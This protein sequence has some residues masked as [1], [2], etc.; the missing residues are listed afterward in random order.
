MRYGL[1]AKFRNPW[2]RRLEE[3]LDRFRALED[4]SSIIKVEPKG[5]PPTKYI[6]TFKGRTLAPGPRGGIVE[7][8]EQKAEIQLGLEYPRQPPTMR[9]LTP[10][11]HPNIWGAGTVCL[12]KFGMDWGPSVYLTE[13]AEVLWDMARFAI[14]NPASAGTSGAKEIDKWAEIGSRFGFPTDQR[15]LRDLVLGADEGSSIL[16]P[17]GEAEDILIIDDETDTCALQ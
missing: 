13:I 5:D 4:E 7:V 9:W 1:G 3:E 11:T 14:L 15:P 17:T 2:T 8:P 10:I 12:P 16:R 6:V